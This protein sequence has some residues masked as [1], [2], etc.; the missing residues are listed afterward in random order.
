MILQLDMGNSR[1][2]WR[3]KLAGQSLSQGAATY[4]VCWQTPLCKQ[5]PDALWVSCVAPDKQRAALIDSCDRWQWPRPQFATTG[6]CFGRLRNGYTHP[7]KLGVDRWLALIAAAARVGDKPCVVVDSGSALT[8]DIIDA[9]GC[10]QGG[11]IA[12]GVASMHRALTNAAPELAGLATTEAY[13][14]LPGKSTAEAIDAAIGAMGAGLI[15]RALALAATPKTGPDCLLTGGDAR[16]WVQYVK[17]AQVVP[18][19]VLDGLQRYFA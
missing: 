13:T 5:V 12:P 4:D 9:G 18:D 17:S 16:V 15:A 8:V 2:K 7:G 10:H 19:L 11:Y 3:L 14:D 1:I 6:E